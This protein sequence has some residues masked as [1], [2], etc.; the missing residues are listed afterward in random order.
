MDLSDIAAIAAIIGVAVGVAKNIYEVGKREGWW[1]RRKPP[2]RR[3]RQPKRQ[4][5]QQLELPLDQPPQ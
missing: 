1:K 3:Q 4:S 5:E 2:R